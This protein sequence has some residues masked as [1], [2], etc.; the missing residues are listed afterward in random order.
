MNYD[1]HSCKD[2]I[3]GDTE[4]YESAVWTN[5]AGYGTVLS[6]G[7]VSQTVVRYK[8]KLKSK[9]FDVKIFLSK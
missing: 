9:L 4:F 3:Q 5:Y 6:V 2:L 1:S 7:M 8:L